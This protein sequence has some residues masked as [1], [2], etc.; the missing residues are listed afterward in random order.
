MDVLSRKLIKQ[1]ARRKVVY[2]F[3]FGDYDDLKPPRIL[4]PGWDYICFTDDPTLRSD[5]W[6]VRLSWRN[7]TDKGLDDKRFATK[8]KILFHQY[9]SGYD[10]SL[11]ID[12]QLELNCDLDCLMRQH[13]RPDD[14]MMICYS[15]HG[16]VYDEAEAGK[17]RLT[18]H[19]ARIDAHMQRYRTEGYPANTGLYMSGIIGR[20]HDRVNVQT[21]C[22]LWWD[23]YGRGSRRDQLSLVYAVWKSTPIK[24]SAL[25]YGEQFFKNRN[26]I[27]HPHKRN[28]HFGGANI[29]FDIPAKPRNARSRWRSR[30]Y[31]GCVDLA[32]CDTIFG[33]AVD[34]NRL[35]TSIS[36]SLYD[37]A[38]MIATVPAEL[39]R[40]DVAAYLGDNGMHGFAIPVPAGLKDN[41]AHQIS[42]RFESTD[43]HLTV[44][45]KRVS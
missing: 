36:V 16:G 11:S 15:E 33:W 41:Q 34:R 5:I 20:R 30:H 44:N 45:P 18:D 17:R 19:P 43:I 35:N 23:E 28:F 12:A 1:D 3:I 39:S 7:E 38:K 6:D 27:T 42:V 21:M 40:P 4:T 14:D 26:F 13:F 22:N 32:N 24:I 9:L 10:L 37:G 25:D 31:M 2:T 8:H 29:Q